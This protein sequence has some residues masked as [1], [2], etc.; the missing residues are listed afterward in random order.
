MRSC[1]RAHLLQELMQPCMYKMA[2]HGQHISM[3]QD[4]EVLHACV[5]V[6][7]L[8]LGR[9]THEQT[10]EASSAQ[11][12][13]SKKKHRF[14][15]GNRQEA[16]SQDP[17]HTGRIHI[18]RAPES[19][20]TIWQVGNCELVAGGISVASCC[21]CKSCSEGPGCEEVKISKGLK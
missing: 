14:L 17:V 3:S 6:P 15:L 1:M 12:K 18:H 2:R 21:M 20:S 5:A 7:R 11:E 10:G 8:K 4:V 9:L 13:P 16:A 19:H